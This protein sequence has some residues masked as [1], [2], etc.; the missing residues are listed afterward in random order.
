MISAKTLTNRQRLIRHSPNGK[1]ERLRH[2]FY[3]VCI[4]VE[5]RHGTGTFIIENVNQE[6]E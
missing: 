2:K 6:L 4:L 5:P 1:S 3:F